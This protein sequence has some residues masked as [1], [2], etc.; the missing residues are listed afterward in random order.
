MTKVIEVSDASFEQEVLGS[1]LPVLVKFGA[2]WCGP[3]KAIEPIL[4]Q[5]AVE[6][7]D[8]LKIVTVNIDEAFELAQEYSIRG[9]PTL[10]TFNGGQ[11][12][13]TKT[14]ALSKSQL[15]EFIKD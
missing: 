14:G 6:L 11:Q 8:T 1:E 10:M 7:A 5:L 2:P 15:L 12:L 9:V 13:K 3:C 4:D